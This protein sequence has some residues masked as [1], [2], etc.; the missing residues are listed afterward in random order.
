M[1]KFSK[2][3]TVFLTVCLLAGV[4]T[5]TVVSAETSST[6]TSILTNDNGSNNRNTSLVNVS[7]ITE[8]GY[9]RYY[10]TDSTIKTSGRALFRHSEIAS[11][12]AN[13]YDYLVYDLDFMSDKYLNETGTDFDDEG[14]K[15]AYVDKLRIYH[16]RYNSASCYL[17]SNGNLWYASADTSYS[18]D[19]IPIE[20]DA[21]IWNHITFV[22]DVDNT[23]TYMFVNGQFLST[24]TTAVSSSTTRDFGLRFDNVVS[25]ALFSFCIDSVRARGYAN[26]YADGDEIAGNSIADYFIGDSTDTNVLLD[27]ADMLYNSNYTYDSASDAQVAASVGG[28]DYHVLDGAIKALKGLSG[29]VT[30]STRKTIAD[31]EIPEAIDTLTVVCTKGA[32][33]SYTG[34]YA[35]TSETVKGDTTTYVIK[36]A[37]FVDAIWKG[38]DGETTIATEQVAVIIENNAVYI[39]DEIAE[40]YSS[41]KGTGRYEWALNDGGYEP[42]VPGAPLPDGVTKITVRP[43]T[44]TV[45]WNGVEGVSDNDVVETWFIGSAL[46]A[47]DLTRFSSYE[48]NDGN[49]WYVI[50]Y[51]AW[52]G[53]TAGMTVLDDEYTFTPELNPVASLIDIKLNMSLLTKFEANLL[54]SEAPSNVYITGVYSNAD[55]VDNLLEALKSL[56]LDGENYLVDSF[57]IDNSDVDKVFSRYVEYEVEYDGCKTVVVG[58]VKVSLIDYAEKVIAQYGCGSKEANLAYNLIN[59]ANA[60]YAFKNGEDYEDAVAFLA[61]EGHEDGCVCNTTYAYLGEEVYYDFFYEEFV[62]GENVYAVSFD[63]SNEQPAFVV[64]VMLDEFG[65]ALAD[66][67]IDFNGIF[68]TEVGGIV[69]NLV[70]GDDITIEGVGTFATLFFENM[71]LYNA[72]EIFTITATDATTGEVYMC[73]YSLASYID[74]MSINADEDDSGL[75]VAK[76]LYSFAKVAKDYKLN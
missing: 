4:V 54:I 65:N 66:V 67:R 13:K 38:V 57:F 5:A 63:V 62:L 1:R 20:K 61:L 48:E 40:I 10:P 18:A 37:R 21:G 33:F 39:P 25:A 34:S 19:D 46:E 53:F 60:A 44:A 27:C 59:Y 23:T 6:I 3:L 15:L 76:A 49:G 58:E 2:I 64:Y 8:N 74:I 42:F 68:G 14:T 70:R 22:Y 28:K 12:L 9:T 32:T 16:D 52:A 45:T 7:K 11:G 50:K 56:E 35:T 29:E 72:T 73:N 47:G 36:K 30:F 26:D 31:F 75:A 17:V 55:C 41:I 51:T 69:L 71:P 24:G 43:V